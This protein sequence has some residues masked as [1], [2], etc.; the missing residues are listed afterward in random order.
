MKREALIAVVIAISLLALRASAQAQ[1]SFFQPPTYAGAGAN[2]FAA[3]FNGDG[4]ID[5]LTADGT[6]NLGNGDGTF[7]LGTA[8][9]GG[10]LAVA[11]FNGDNKPDVL[12][13]GTGTLLVR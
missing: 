11:D 6:M 3:D 13:Q 2:S 9:S 10:A 1:V 8:V 4:K 12:Q 7:K 5:L